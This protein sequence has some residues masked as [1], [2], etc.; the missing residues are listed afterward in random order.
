MLF[1]RLWN[2]IRG[3]VIIL[4]K[5]YFLEKFINISTH[6]QIYLWDI[7]KQ[8]DGSLNLKASIKGFKMLRPVA[9]K[10][11]CKIRI[12]K[13]RGVPFILNKYR[14][15]KAFLGGGILFFAMMFVLTSFVWTVEV[16]GNKNINP[17]AIIHR[18]D[19]MGIHPGT[20]KYG[21]DTKNIVSN[22][23]LQFDD[24]SWASVV[25][26]G[27]KIKVEIA[28]SKEKPQMIRKD[29]PCNIVSSKDAVV[30]DVIAKAGQQKVKPGDTVTK[31]QILISGIV[32][33]ENDENLKKNVHAMGSVTARTWYEATRPVH[34]ILKGE[35]RTGIEKDY[36]TLVLFSRK[37]SL[38]F[39]KIP[40]LSYD[41]VLIDKKLSL[42]EDYELPFEIE[43]EKYYEKKPFEREISVDDAKNNAIS[44]AYN[45]IMSKL[46]GNA[47]IVDSNTD[48]KN[49]QDGE[50]NCE[51]TVE[52][53][54]EIGEEQAF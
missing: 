12:Q 43:T 24:I 32:D 52:C 4:V 35:E 6:R 17:E 48:F 47:K 2:Y 1:L 11:G 42:G 23:M 5:G 50:L 33:I 27:T 41:R 22:I 7:K 26:K 14:R 39:G 54:E 31:G 29:V 34:T 44:G 30:K 18:L 9:K 8:K 19:L 13:K 15:R 21:I 3:Y 25:V 49:G 28:E 36:Y 16:T 37:I 20:F 10:T 51:V 53:V 45:E 40:F 46:P 38:K